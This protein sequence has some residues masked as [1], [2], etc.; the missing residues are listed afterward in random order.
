MMDWSKSPIYSALTRL[1]SMLNKEAILTFKNIMGFMGDRVMSFPNMLAREVLEK[2]IQ[3]PDLRDEIYIQIIKQVTN[4]PNP[5][6]TEK[7]WKMMKMCLDCFPPSREFENYLEIYFRN[8]DPDSPY[9]KALHQIVWS[10]NVAV[11]PTPE[12]IASEY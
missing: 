10:G 3:Q 11:P 4:N 1:P 12:Q 6:S 5:S 2:G 8:R 9:R 7:G